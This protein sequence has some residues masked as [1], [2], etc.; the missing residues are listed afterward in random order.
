MFDLNNQAQVSGFTGG[1]PEIRTIAKNGNK[2]ANFSVAST[3]HYTNDNGDRVE[4]TEWHRC[5]AFGK[6]AEFLERNLEKG[7]Y[8]TVQGKL[9]TKKFKRKVKIGNKEH[10]V[11]AQSTE[12]IVN[13]CDIK[14]LAKKAA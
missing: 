5:V 3:S 7:K 6:T 8:I 2:V 13:T 14:S 9:R 1:D 12:I 11:D 4:Q 10:E